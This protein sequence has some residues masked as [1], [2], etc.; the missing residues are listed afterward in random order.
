[1][2]RRRTITVVF[3]VAVLVTFAAALA[4]QRYLMNLG[5]VVAIVVAAIAALGTFNYSVE[6]K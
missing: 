4:G 6:E 1:M 3:V 2:N 5:A